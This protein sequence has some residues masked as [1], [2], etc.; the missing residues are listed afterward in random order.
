MRRRYVQD[1]ETGDL[2]EVG[3]DY[4]PRKAEAA[5]YVIPDITPYRSM[6]TGEVIGSRSVH[7]EH[8]RRHGLIEVGNESRALEKL[9]PPPVSREERRRA[10]AAV[11]NNR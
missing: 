3:A 8:L 4:R 5:H 9:R 7:R 11:M 6:Q 10:I 2:I 1:R